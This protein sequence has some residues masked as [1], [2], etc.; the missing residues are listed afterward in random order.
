MPS[1]SSQLPAPCSIEDLPTSPDTLLR[2]L[3]TLGI[4]YKVYNHKAVFTVAENKA[5][6]LGIPGA[7][8]RNL[9]LRDQKGKM[10]LVTLR[11]D[12]PVDLKKLAPLLGMGRLSFGSPERLWTYLGVRPGSVT[13]FAMINDTGHAVTLVLEAG[14][15][16]QDIL[17]CH[18][19]IN[20]M[21]VGL[22]PQ[23]LIDFMADIGVTSR[24]VDLSTAAPS[25]Q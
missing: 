24:I 4:P 6:D 14:L 8:T 5:S 13:P 1:E 19:L 10:V 21:T 18:P 7:H 25:D 11:H 9:F 17:T 20:T 3:E 2:R 12:T 15:M 22:T 16:D 23:G